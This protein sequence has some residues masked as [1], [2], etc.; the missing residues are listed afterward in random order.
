MSLDYNEILETDFKHKEE[1]SFIFL[2]EFDC[3]DFKGAVNC[4]LH[5]LGIPMHL[6]TIIPILDVVSSDQAFDNVFMSFI[7]VTESDL[8]RNFIWR[9]ARI[10]PL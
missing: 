3:H 9:I 7:M 10:P 5:V 2:F 6:D 4:V 1:V 8:L